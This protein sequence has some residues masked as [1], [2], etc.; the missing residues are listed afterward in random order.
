MCAA[1]QAAPVAARLRLPDRAAQALTER[2]YSKFTPLR[3]ELV[4]HSAVI[5]APLQR[6]H[7]VED[8]G[9]PQRP[10]FHAARVI[11]PHPFY[12]IG[13]IVA[14]LE[15]L[16]NGGQPNLA[17][18]VE[19]LYR[20]A[21]HAARPCVGLHLFPCQPKCLFRPNLIDLR[22]LSRCSSRDNSDFHWLISYMCV[23]TSIM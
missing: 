6:D 12:W 3:A 8:R 19:A 20:D 4:F 17:V 7:A 11:D 13:L 14:S 15:L 23:R 5:D 10:L 18:F 21:I 9:Y 2:L 16:F 1:A 22:L